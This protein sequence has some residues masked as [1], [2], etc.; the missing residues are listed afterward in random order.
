VFGCSLK[1]VFCIG[2]GCVGCTDFINAAHSLLNSMRVT[3]LYFRTA[4]SRV[5]DVCTSTTVTKELPKKWNVG[6]IYSAVVMVFLW[7][8]AARMFSVFDR[9]D[10]FGVVLLL[11]LSSIPA[12]ALSTLLQTASFVACQT[13]N[14]DRVFRDARLQKPDAASCRRLAVTLTTVSWVLV[15]TNFVFVLLTFI[16]EERLIFISTPI[17]V[18][19][20]ASGALLVA[21]KTLCALLMIVTNHILYF[22]Y[23]VNYTLKS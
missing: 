13:G 15:A 9:A 5:N 19:V 2:R 14:L 4:S 6:R 16:D 18:H 12:A 11:K 7:L 3:G 21:T 23:S 8:N 22:A 20:F 17:G 10:K 1:T